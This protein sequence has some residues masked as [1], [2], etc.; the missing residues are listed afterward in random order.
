ME[1]NKLDTNLSENT[2][3]INGIEYDISSFIKSHPGG[4]VIKYSIGTDATRVFQEFHYR[5]EKAK[6]ILNSWNKD[7]KRV[8][9]NK[10]VD[11][12]I[13]LT[14]DFESWRYQL[15]KEGFFEPSLLHVCYRIIE[16]ILIFWLGLYS[17]SKGWIFTSILI[18]GIFGCRCGWVQHECGHNSFTGYP[19]ID[20][21]IQSIT[22]GFGLGGSGSMWN[23]MHNKH[24]ATPQKE[25]HDMD[26]D[27]TPLVAF[28]DKAFEKNRKRFTLPLWWIKFQAYLFIPVTSGIFIPIFWMY[29]LHPRIVI[30]KR[31]YLQL[32][33]MLSAH[34]IRT[35]LFQVY[36]GYES[37][38]YSYFL[39]FLLPI[40]VSGMLLFGHFTLSH[41]FMPTID[42]KNNK[43]WVRSALE[44]TV[45][46]SPHNPIVC[47]FMGYLNCQVIHHLFPTM[48]Q[49]RQPY[50]YTKLKR[51]CKKNN[52]EYHVIGYFEALSK[53]FKNMDEVG[54]K[55]YRQ[56]SKGL[57]R[58]KDKI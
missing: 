51:F 50:I 33:S 20:K 58:T 41:S 53:T 52:L 11:N 42:E 23:V 8:V 48:P 29:Y 57:L 28:Y 7:K 34:I 30:R 17:A 45:D 4:S 27:T 36:T 54:K 21:V 1:L 24:H 18:H 43:N 22:I 38:F 6:K 49:F 13:Q 39:G 2:L 40:W 10:K 15:E 55:L 12:D 32:F 31:K 46:I 19:K 9:K 35:Y 37:I 44:H 3:I 26:L 5:S 56:M 16:L 25:K 47:W 14:N